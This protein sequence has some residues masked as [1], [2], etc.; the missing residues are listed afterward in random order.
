MILTIDDFSFV[1]NFI[2]S[3][4][5]IVKQELVIQ[6]LSDLCLMVLM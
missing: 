1:S 5:A 2:T 3:T 6:I 4:A